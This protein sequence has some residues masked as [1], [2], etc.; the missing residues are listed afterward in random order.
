MFNMF[1]QYVWYSWKVQQLLLKFRMNEFL[2]DG[3]AEEVT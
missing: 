3:L 2:Q 1:C